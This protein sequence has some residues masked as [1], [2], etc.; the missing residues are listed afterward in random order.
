[1]CDAALGDSLEI[2]ADE[3]RRRLPTE[4][5]H[6]NWIGEWF[7]QLSRKE[8]WHRAGWKHSINQKAHGRLIP[9][10]KNMQ[11]ALDS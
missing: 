1:M 3:L 11:I 5:L 10:W 7:R 6:P 4:P 9:I 8:G 2:D